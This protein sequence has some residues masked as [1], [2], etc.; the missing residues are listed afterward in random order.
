M[1]DT[2]Q[3]VADLIDL[4]HSA[5]NRVAIAD[6]LLEQDRWDLLPTILE[7]L[8]CGTQLIIDKYCIKHK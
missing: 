8:Y 7:E 5:K 1:K 4:L 2:A 6:I 3:E